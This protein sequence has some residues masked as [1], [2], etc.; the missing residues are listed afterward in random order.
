[1]ILAFKKQ[2]VSPI[3]LGTKIHTIR[4]DKPDRWQAG[5][6][7][8]MATGIRSQNYNC[9][10]TAN[11]ISTQQIVI[12]YHG[13]Q[14]TVHV[15]GRQLSVAEMTLLAKFDGFATIA[16]FAAWFNEDLTGKIIHWTKFKY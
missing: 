13:L 11:C 5:K 10:A 6:V 15:D 3:Q 4:E 9:F 16:D 14:W 2:F 8:H 12:K 7:I 1:M